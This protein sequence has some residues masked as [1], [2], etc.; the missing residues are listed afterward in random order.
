MHYHR[1]DLKTTQL[2]PVFVSIFKILFDRPNFSMVLCQALRSLEITED[3]LEHFSNVFHLSS[4]E[5]IGI[6]LALCD[7][8]IHEARVAGE[9]CI[10]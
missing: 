5:K 1:E 9:Y 2:E 6:G 3:F 7:L 8:E 4:C 10:I